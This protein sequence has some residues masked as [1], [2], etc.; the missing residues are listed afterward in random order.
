MPKK[1][2]P[3][4][5]TATPLRGRGRPKGSKNKPK[6]VT[7]VALVI[8]RSG[9]MNSVRQSAFDGINE[10]ISTIKKNVKLTGKT[11]VTYIQFD[12]EIETVFENKDAKDLTPITYN[13]YEPRGTTA[14]RDATLTAIKS[15]QSAGAKDGDDA[16]YLV[17]VISDGAENASKDITATEL[18]A[19][20]TKLEATG[21]WTFTYMLSNVDSQAVAASLGVSVGNVSTYHATLAGT[22]DAFSQMSGSY[23]AYA[24]LRSSG[25]RGTNVFYNSNSNTNK[26]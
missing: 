23:T 22:T 25:V 24:S 18:K 4:D 3:T 19:E 21:N 2:A 8:D 5:V 10:Q 11:Y 12:Q 26:K 9:S 14:L 13:Q 15:L 6:K 17:V 7:R 16:G 20:I 1:K